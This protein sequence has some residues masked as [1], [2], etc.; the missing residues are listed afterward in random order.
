[1]N[2]C[3]FLSY[4]GIHNLYFTF[5]KPK[6]LEKMADFMRFNIDVLKLPTK[7]SCSLQYTLY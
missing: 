4:K 5:F 3:R 6:Y 1:M 7:L 2:V